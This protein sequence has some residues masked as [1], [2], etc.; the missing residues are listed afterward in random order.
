MK[1]IMLSFEQK[2]KRYY[3]LDQEKKAIEKEHKPLN[4]EIKEYMRTEE[5]DSFTVEDIVAELKTQERKN[6][7]AEKLVARLKELGFTEAIQTVEV[8]NEEKINELI[9]E[10]KLDPNALSDCVEIKPVYVLSV[11]KV[12]GA[13]KSGK[14]ESV[15]S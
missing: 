11:K 5:M 9:Y 7:N 3:E 15:Q 6:M 8:P 12:K 4:E 1:R 13:K 14:S 2:V 10:Q